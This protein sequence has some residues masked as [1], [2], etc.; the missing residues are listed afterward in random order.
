[1]THRSELEQVLG[2]AASH[3]IQRAKVERW[4]VFFLA[5]AELFGYKNGSEWIV[6]HYLMR[7]R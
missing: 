3:R 1:M 4:R 7:A 5:C 6:A 2:P